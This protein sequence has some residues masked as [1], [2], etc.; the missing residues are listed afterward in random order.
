MRTEAW[1]ESMKACEDGERRHRIE[2]KAL[3]HLAAR[4]K[5]TY[6]YHWKAG[7]HSLLNY[8]ASMASKRL[9]IVASLLERD[10]SNATAAEV[11]RFMFDIIE[12]HTG[13]QCQ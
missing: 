3:E 11:R 13:R 7:D 12:P 2:R 9:N 4:H 6:S 8:N 10:G 5:P 1:K